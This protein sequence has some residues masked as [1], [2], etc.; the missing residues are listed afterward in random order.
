MKLYK[1]KIFPRSS[2][3]TPWQ[4]DTLMGSIC[5]I[6]RQKEGEDKLKEI[7]Q[8]YANGVY[9]FVVSGCFP[10][11]YLPKPMAG[12]EYPIEEGMPKTD[13]LNN[14]D[15]DKRAKEEDFLTLD[16]FNTLISGR[17]TD[18][19]HKGNYK[20]EV[21]VMHN[22]ISRY[23]NTTGTGSLYEQFETF[24]PVPYLTMYAYISDGYKEYFSELLEELSK[25]GYGKRTSI[26]KGAFEIQELEEFTG[27]IKPEKP[28]CFISLSNYIPAKADP[29]TGQYKT[30]VKYGKLG[31]GY[32]LTENP[33]KNPLL[34]MPPGAVF[35]T[36]EP[37]NIYGRLVK[38]ISV[39][40]SNVVQFGLTV[41]LPGRIKKPS[42]IRGEV[43][44]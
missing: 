4:S 34:I 30:F 21:G 39:S 35:W 13:I 25:K 29:T 33:F 2:Q 14:A 40:H 5:W 23:T 27:F 20:V 15:R 3:I 24:W 28:N 17:Q 19:N 44:V 26:G 22:T 37:K 12:S 43:L 1:V 11:D 32:G 16:E 38:N 8:L 18:I 42:S 10:G 6:I 7:I 9:P 31:Q 41:A 36:H